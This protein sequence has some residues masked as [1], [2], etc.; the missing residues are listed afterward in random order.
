M[1]LLIK[2]FLTAT[3]LIYLVDSSMSYELF[4]EKRS[5]G[6]WCG[7]GVHVT[8]VDYVTYKKCQMPNA[9]IGQFRHELKTEEE[10]NIQ[11]SCVDNYR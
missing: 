7:V 8:L 5:A 10:S 4:F 2:F 11:L 1:V 9:S 3:D 6:G